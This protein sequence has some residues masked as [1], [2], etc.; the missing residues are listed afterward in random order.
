MLTIEPQLFADL[1]FGFE[2][3]APHLGCASDQRGLEEDT[4]EN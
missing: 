4:A 1:P 2:T 3:A